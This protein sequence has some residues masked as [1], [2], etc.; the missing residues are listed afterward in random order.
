MRF[1]LLGELFDFV[2]DVSHWWLPRIEDV[3]SRFPNFK[4]VI[5]KRRKEDTVE[6]FLRIKGN[7]A[8]GAIN[9]WVEHSGKY[10]QKNDW[11]PCYP[12]Y[13]LNN[14]RVALEAYW[15]EYYEVSHRLS[16]KHHENVRVFEIEVLA[17]E[18][19]QREILDFCGFTNPVILDNVHA[20]KGTFVDG[21]RLWP[22]PIDL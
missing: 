3:K 20:N 6:S 5:L 18:E 4:A 21:I 7:D 1:E 9:H 17:T 8:K 13:P 2:A 12:S 19:G 11:D 22:V 10:W 14:S 15:D 16:E